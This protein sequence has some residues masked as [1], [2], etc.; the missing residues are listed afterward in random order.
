MREDQEEFPHDINVDIEAP[1]LV[2]RNSW[3][4]WCPTS[5][6]ALRDAEKRIM[7]FVRTAWRGRFVDIGPCVNEESCKVI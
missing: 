7:Q 2:E 5:M 6:A 1:E 3:L 4:R